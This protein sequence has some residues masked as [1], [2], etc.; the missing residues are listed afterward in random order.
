VKVEIH[1]QVGSVAD[2]LQSLAQEEV[3]VPF[4][5]VFIDADKRSNWSYLSTLLGTDQMRSLLSPGAL[6]ITDNT[7]WKGRVLTAEQASDQVAHPPKDKKEERKD[8]LTKMI[9]EFN[10]R[11]ASHPFL[12]TVMIPLRDGLTVSRYEPSSGS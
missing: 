12:K 2:L 8:L 3:R 4:D 10:L 7:L 9:H 11:C 1:L 5:L 6:I